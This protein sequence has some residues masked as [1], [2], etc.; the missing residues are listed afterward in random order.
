MRKFDKCVV[1]TRVGSFYE[2]YFEHAEEYGPLL[3]LKVAQK[4]T[5]A[6]PVYMSGF[7]FFQLDRFL[8]IL[9]QDLNKYVAISEEFPND[10]S[11]KV[12]SGGLDYDRKVIRV[13][14]PGTLIDEKFMDPYENNYLL[15]IHT[16]SSTSQTDA[17]TV[18][19]IERPSASVQ[20]TPPPKSVG[21]A[22]LDLSSGDFFTQCTD[23]A[24]LSSI[25]ARI[26]PRE[27]IL[28]RAVEDDRDLD[29]LTLLK[30]DDH[31]IAYHQLA[32]SVTSVSGWSSMLEA[33]LSAEDDSRFAPEELTAGALLLQYVKTQLQ[34]TKVRLQPPT[35][36]HDEDFMIVDKHTMRA[37]EIRATL[38]DGTHQGS[39]VH[40]IR[41]TVTKSGA[42]LLSQRLASPSTSIPIITERLNLVSEMRDSS[43]TRQE[44]VALLRRTFDTLRLVQ[45]FAFGRGDADDLLGI[46]RTVE[47][48][49]QVAY[50]LQDYAA[51]KDETSPA[52]AM[53][54]SKALKMN[55]VLEVLGR[56]SLDGPTK[57]AERIIDAI[58]ED[59][60]SQQHRIEEDEAAVA[61]GLV[62]KMVTEE[63]PG[64]KI[65][66]QSKRISG[67]PNASRSDDG[68]VDDVWIMRRNASP[69]LESLHKDLDG[70]KTQKVGLI[71]RLRDQSG[72]PSLT[73]RWTS[74]GHI[75]HVKSK[76]DMS[77]L[78]AM[79]GVQG[80]GSTK[81]TQSFYLPEWTRLGGH[82]EQ[83]KL[84]IRTEE[85][86]VFKDLR[87]QVIVNLVK[88]RRNAAVLDEL[89]VAC[90]FA[91][92]AEEQNWVRP[93][94]NMSTQH[95]IV[96]G[97]HP[98]VEVGL[99]EQG[100]SFTSNDCFVGADERILLITGPNMAGKSTFLRQNA[101]IAILAQT[102][103]FVPADYA[104]IG[105][106]DRMFSRVGSADNLYQDQS[107]FMVEMLE[108]ATILRRATPRSFVRLLSRTN[109][110]ET[111]SLQVIMD[112]VGRGTTPED[113]IAVGG[114]NRKS[115]AL[116]VARLAGLPEEAITVAAQVFEE[117]TRN[118]SDPRG[119]GST[120]ES[121][122]A[123]TGS[124]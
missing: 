18:D 9:V 107:T 7:P 82:I 81:S 112:E 50:H 70:L 80:I 8:K 10:A 35:H 41:R 53:A 110:F 79:D 59:G 99:S 32:E 20:K 49:Q 84:R 1:L 92:L 105:I 43:P 115:H 60:L 63:A 57:L 109:L 94:L 24:S 67:S 3:N 117:L 75:C 104:E 46:A 113:G 98:M 5:K 119:R 30:A 90:S 123:A 38:R 55:S 69:I 2:L 51:L 64:E 28:D 34:G 19:P 17:Q 23:L 40:A 74:Q 56:L 72:I 13:V 52:D 54:I 61:A 91:I 88:L 85:Q 11:E 16:T 39:L 29:L 97:R 124:G 108:T 58:D 87:S 12:K 27:I 68:E 6:G 44:L 21:L 71:G 25:I 101:L 47:I 22:W 122:A 89:D 86:R 4:K 31:T 106:V 42:R 121:K 103:S 96:G 48:M 83:Q 33:P 100:R 78:R 118:G 102:G 66:G 37:L 111:K 26:G 120:E 65:P 73:L 95:K 76:K 114:V 93:I 45:K 15:S 62:Q 36:I 116:K 77:S 14:T